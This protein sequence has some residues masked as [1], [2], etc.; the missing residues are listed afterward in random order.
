MVLDATKPDGS[1]FVSSLDTYGQETR[2]AV[3]L[4]TVHATSDGSQHTFID[5]SVISGAAPTLLGTNFTVIPDAAL[6]SGATVTSAGAGDSGKLVKLDASGALDSTVIGASFEITALA[7]TSL[8]ASQLVRCNA[9]GTA[10]ESS[11]KTV[12]TGDIVG[13]SDTQVLAAK[14]LTLP[15]I[16]DTSSDHQYVFAVNELSA[17]RTVTLPLLTGNDTFTFNAFAATLTNKTLT[18][19]QI[20]GGILNVPQIDD[21]TGDHQYVFVASELAADRTVTLPLLA[22]NDTFVFA[23]FIQTLTNKTLTTPTIASFTNATHTHT[24]AASGGALTGVVLTTPLIADG[25]TGVSITSADQTHA[26]PTITIPDIVDAADVFCVLDTTQTLTNKTIA[27]A[28]HTSGQAFANASTPGAVYTDGVYMY[29]SDI[30]AGNSSMHFMCEDG[31]IIKLYE[32][33]HADQGDA[34]AMTVIGDNTGTS[35]VGLSL[36]GDTSSVNQAAAIMNDFAALKEDINALD[37]LL[38]SI[39]DALIAHGLIKGSV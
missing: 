3:N 7:V 2:V 34:G 4:N 16:N 1:D 17:D 14:V 6:S 31:N 15:Q 37:V 33:A 20:N 11:G 13:T 30:V 22:G 25:D 36:I 23:D 18:S 21:T 24:D 12:P 9:A 39:R 32:V 28:V 29:A 26:A 19:P 38:S 35:A 5:Q 8:T 10:V 27:A